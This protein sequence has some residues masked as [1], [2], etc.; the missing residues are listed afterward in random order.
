MYRLEDDTSSGKDVIYKRGVKLLGWD[1]TRE[2]TYVLPIK[3]KIRA[4]RKEKLKPIYRKAKRD[5][6]IVD[7]P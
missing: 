4:K 2:E 7:H 5:V 3:L 6:D 1:K